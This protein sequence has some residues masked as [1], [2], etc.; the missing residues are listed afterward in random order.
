MENSDGGME[1]IN[2]MSNQVDNEQIKAPEEKK[3]QQ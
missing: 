1:Q 2:S 3:M